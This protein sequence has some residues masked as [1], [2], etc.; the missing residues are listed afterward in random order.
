MASF[1]HRVIVRCL[2]LRLGSVVDSVVEGGVDNV[3]HERGGVQVNSVLGLGDGGGN[4]LGR[5]QFPELEVARVL[6]DGGTQHRGGGRLSLSLHDLLLLL[7][8]RLLHQVGRPLRL[9]LRDL[10]GLHGRGV[11]LAERELRDRD[12]VQDNIK[13]SRSVRQLLPYQQGYLDNKRE[14]LV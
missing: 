11:L 13:I 14:C 2:V 4:F 7:L 6:A 5:G 10:L 1:N 3:Q 8:P 12:V 9:L